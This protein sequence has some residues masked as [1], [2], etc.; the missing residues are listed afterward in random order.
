MMIPEQLFCGEYACDDP[1]PGNA[2]VN[3][4][5]FEW[6]W[7]EVNY[8]NHV[9]NLTL[10]A[11]EREYCDSIGAPHGSQLDQEFYDDLY[12]EEEEHIV[13][14]WELGKDGLYHIVPNCNGCGY[15]AS[16]VW[17]GGAPLVVV[18]WSE[19]IAHVKSLCSPC[20]PGQAD[21]D[22]GEGNI[23]AYT[24]PMED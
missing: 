15:A 19:T 12:L 20:C 21:L 6:L 11:I 8:G 1:I 24:L 23:A 17:L 18:E 22:S 7:D 9:I 4:E 16:V 5:Q 2:Y 14:D 3:S 13:G 10:E